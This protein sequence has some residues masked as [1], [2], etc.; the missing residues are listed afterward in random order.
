MSSWLHCLMGAI[1]LIQFIVFLENFSYFIFN[2]Y[3]GIINLL[4]LFSTETINSIINM[5]SRG[6]T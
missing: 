3:T 2:N 6:L 5:S 4:K 1:V